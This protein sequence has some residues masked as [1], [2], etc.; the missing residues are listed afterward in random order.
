MGHPGYKWSLKPEG[1]QWRWQA[2]D[3]DGGAVFV[4]GMANSRAEA[5]ACLA[6]AMTLGVLGQRDE[7]A[8]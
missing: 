6:R 2:V 1:G 7:V 5:A 4:Q 8:A 3:R